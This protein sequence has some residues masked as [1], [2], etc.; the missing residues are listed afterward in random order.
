MSLI[1][2]EEPHRDDGPIPEYATPKKVI[3]NEIDWAEFSAVAGRHGGS[4]GAALHKLLK[5]YRLFTGITEKDWEELSRISAETGS[6]GEAVHEM[7]KTYKIHKNRYD[8]VAG[9]FNDSIAER[10]TQQL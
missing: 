4:S 6:M 9:G 5:V 1:P 10:N 8:N 2:A 3:T 7:I